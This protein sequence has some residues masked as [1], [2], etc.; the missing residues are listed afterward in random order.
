MLAR[1]GRSALV[2]VVLAAPTVALATAALTIDSTPAA[3]AP[4]AT[5]VIAEVQ[6]VESNH[7]QAVRVDLQVGAAPVLRAP[8]WGG[9]VNAVLVGPGDVIANGTP[10]VVV[11]RVQRW[12]LET[13]EP[14]TRPLRHG[15]RG[16]DVAQL[17]AALNALGYEP[18]TEDG[19]YGSATAAAVRSLQVDLGVASPSR[20]FDPSHIVWL[21]ANTLRAASVALSPA[22]P[23]PSQGAEIVTGEQPVLTG[24]LRTE[25]GAS[26]SDPGRGVELVVGDERVGETPTSTL[27]Q[28]QVVQ[29]Y[30]ALRDGR[31]AERQDPAQSAAPSDRI[32]LDGL[33]RLIVPASVHVV[34]A[35]AL[36]GEPGGERECI[37]LVDGA[38]F[39]PFVTAAVGGAL[40]VVHID[41]A[42]PE[43]TR[44][45]ANP[46]SVLDATTCAS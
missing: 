46:L 14:L 15:D 10:I 39:A 42:P 36:V 33:T 17:Q 29:L 37:Y 44:V 35:S 31:V 40:G 26:L 6:R 19:I 30:E 21:P 3:L 34:P 24:S 18:G 11:D 32:E 16:A 43:G 1:L 22:T 7:E 28:G 20:T 12:A 38:S 9:V 4:T 45:L 27:D 5:A 23:A 8:A 25:Q 41:P 2:L 13:A